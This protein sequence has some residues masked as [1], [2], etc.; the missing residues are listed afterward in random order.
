MFKP[1]RRYKYSTSQSAKKLTEIKGAIE[2]TKR[3]MGEDFNET[4]EELKRR[5]RHHMKEA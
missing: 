4:E 3:A 5:P 1:T 2:Q